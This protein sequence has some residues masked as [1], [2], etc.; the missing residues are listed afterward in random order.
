MTVAQLL[1]ALMKMPDEAV[2][3]TEGDG[4]F[5]LVTDLDYIASDGPGMPA[6]VILLPSMDE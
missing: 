2:V 6:E 4:G 5:S 1:A 3:L